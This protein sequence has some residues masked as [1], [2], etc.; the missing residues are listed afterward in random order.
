[1]SL[2]RTLWVA[3]TVTVMLLFGSALAVIYSKY[4]TRLL[5]VRIQ[6]L[7]RHSDD[8]E[9]QWGKLQL[10]QTTLASEHRVE[11]LARK[12]LKLTLPDRTEIVYLKP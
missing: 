12:E 4:R 3:G 10:E 6:Q 9:V 2:S 5:F 8:L 7:E 1:M 11:T